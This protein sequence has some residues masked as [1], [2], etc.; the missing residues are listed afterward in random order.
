M[1]VLV[2]VSEL[3]NQLVSSCV[4]ENK[5]KE[6]TDPFERLILFVEIPALD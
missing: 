5:A 2:K 4:C 3:R 1:A 6:K